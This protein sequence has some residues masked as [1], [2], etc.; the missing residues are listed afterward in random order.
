MENIIK[1]IRDWTT[2]F[3]QSKI[4]DSK[5]YTD[6]KVA[7]LIISVPETLDIDIG[8]KLDKDGD[9]SNTTATFTQASTRENIASGEK[10]SVILGKIKKFFA[11]LKTVAF[12]GS[13]NDLSDKPDM[14]NFLSTK[15]GGTVNNTFKVNKESTTNPTGLT[16]IDIHNDGKVAFNTS[17]T[18][19]NKDSLMH[20]EG[21]SESGT[22]TMLGELLHLRGK[23]IKINKSLNTINTGDITLQHVGGEADSVKGS[24]IY[25][26]NDNITINAPSDSNQLSGAIHLLAGKLDI[27]CG[28]TSKINIY[29]HSK[30][31]SEINIEA[32]KIGIGTDNNLFLDLYTNNIG[33]ITKIRAHNYNTYF[34]EEEGC[35]KMIPYGS[36]TLYYLI[37]VINGAIGTKEHPWNKLYLAEGINTSGADFNVALGDNAG[38][39]C[40]SMPSS[41]KDYPSLRPILAGGCTLGT[42]TYKWRTIYATSGTIQTSDRN[43]KNT[44]EELSTEQA[45]SL[46]LGLKP[47][48]YKMNDGSSGR[49]HWGM[50]SQDIEELMEKLG[51]DSTK[52]AGF[53][54]STKVR[55]I[56][57]DEN[58]NP[59]KKPI[60]E[61][62]EGEYDYSLRYDEFI[63]PMIKV[64]QNLNDRMTLI[65][66][67]IQQLLPSE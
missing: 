31:N 2:A 21:N 19:T 24:S 43:E 60:E 49:T 41:S 56:T 10:T 27:G 30:Y 11:D 52:F 35:I 66:Q 54:K 50:I 22:I 14:S 48:T 6:A 45:K 55:T 67:Q 42:N 34:G 25:I 53:I 4:D 47:S 44:I 38:G 29:A 1:A 39:I 15:K 62:V 59:L 33:P 8:K 57:E 32:S 65:E 61:V 18:G 5:D 23:K 28:D 20:L 17:D 51:W 7:D 63:A 40:I 9:T 26:N 46:I 37:D 3:V 58:G 13:Y 36:K 16:E 12:T 64:I